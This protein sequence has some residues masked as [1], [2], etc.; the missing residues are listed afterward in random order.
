MYVS[1]Y[2]F[3]SV[4]NDLRESDD[5]D[6]KILTVQYKDF[7]VFIKQC[8]LIIWSV[9]KIQKVKTQKLQRKMNKDVQCVIVSFL[10]GNILF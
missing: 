4:N 5:L 7:N 6:V 10:L 2:E 9:E 8:Y 1:N 3:A